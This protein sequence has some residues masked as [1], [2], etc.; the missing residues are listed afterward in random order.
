MSEFENSFILKMFVFQFL[1]FYTAI[2]YIA[3]FKGK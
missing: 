2:F 3:F 1:N